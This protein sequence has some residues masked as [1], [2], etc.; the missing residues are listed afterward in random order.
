MKTFN[1]I[2]DTDLIFWFLEIKPSQWNNGIWTEWEVQI[3]YVQ[4]IQR[5]NKEIRDYN[6]NFKQ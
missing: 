3:Q 1:S 2:L 4:E 5:G 6:H